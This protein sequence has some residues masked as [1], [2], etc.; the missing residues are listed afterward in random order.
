MEVFAAYTIL[1]GGIKRPGFGGETCTLLF[2]FIRL[3][4]FIAFDNFHSKMF[5]PN[6]LLVGQQACGETS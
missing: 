2:T 6:G 4:W 1:G 5:L 3:R